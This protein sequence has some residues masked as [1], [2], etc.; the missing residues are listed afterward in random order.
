MSKILAL[1]TILKH[2][3]FLSKIQTIAL[4]LF[5]MATSNS[6]ATEIIPTIEITTIHIDNEPF[7][8]VE[9]WIYSSMRLCSFVVLDIFNK[10]Q[11]IYPELIRTFWRH[12]EFVNKKTIAS[13][14]A[15][16]P[17]IFFINGFFCFL[18]DEWQRNGEGR[19]RGDD[20]SRR[21]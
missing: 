20:T 1:F 16:L 5:A 4:K 13:I 18:E 8:H 14:G 10:P 21:R 2:F 19:E 7:I 9:K 6:P 15:C 11:T 17:R 3:N 12:V